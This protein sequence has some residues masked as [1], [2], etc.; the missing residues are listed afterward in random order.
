LINIPLA[1]NIFIPLFRAPKK[2]ND[3][4]VDL[5]YEGLG[6]GVLPLIKFYITPA[7]LSIYFFFSINFKPFYVLVS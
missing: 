3:H 7:A 4:K 6:I 2:P 5:T 1:T